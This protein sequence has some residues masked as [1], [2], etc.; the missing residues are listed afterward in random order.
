M[1]DRKRSFKTKNKFTAI[2][3]LSQ[4]DGLITNDPYEKA[5]SFNIFFLENSKIDTTGATLPDTK[6]LTTA[7]LTSMTFTRTDQN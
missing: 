2:P 6:F 7:R 3:A 1:A 5:T 4:Q